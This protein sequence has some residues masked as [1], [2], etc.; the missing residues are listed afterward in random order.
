MEEVRDQALEHRPRLIVAGTTSY[1]RR[2]DPEPFTRSP[3][4]WARC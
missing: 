3:T 2:L 4:R 1:P